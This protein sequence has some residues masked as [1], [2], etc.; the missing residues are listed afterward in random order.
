[1]LIGRVQMTCEKYPSVTLVSSRPGAPGT[2]WS[3]LRM[4]ATVGCASTSAWA[5]TSA[6]S[7]VRSTWLTCWTATAPGDTPA[8]SAFSM[9]RSLS[10]LRVTRI[11]TCTCKSSTSVYEVPA[12]SHVTS[13]GGR[14]P[15]GTQ[16][17]ARPRIFWTIWCS[18]YWRTGEYIGVSS[19]FSL[20]RLI[21]TLTYLE[22]IRP[23]PTSP[24]LVSPSVRLCYFTEFFDAG[25]EE[26]VH[27]THHLQATAQNWR[28]VFN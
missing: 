1:M 21:N 6:T 17:S 25:F 15:T 2:S 11:S 5:R 23:S 18:D 8:R 20:L 3:L 10:R 27:Q 24:I 19:L 7:G 16:I 26:F 14:D 4:R 22:T 12:H 28:R 9:R 13:L